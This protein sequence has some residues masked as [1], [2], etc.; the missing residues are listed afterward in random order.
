MWF[1]SDI[2]YDIYC[3]SFRSYSNTGNCNLLMT[4]FWQLYTYDNVLVTYL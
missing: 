4:M 1:K 2:D 3:K